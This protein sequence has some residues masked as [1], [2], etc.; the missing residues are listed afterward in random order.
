M[1]KKGVSKKCAFFVF[2]F[3]L[4]DEANE[5]DGKTWKRKISKKKQKSSVFWVQSLEHNVCVVSSKV[6][7]GFGAPKRILR[8]R[9]PSLALILSVSTGAALG[10]RRVFVRDSLVLLWTLYVQP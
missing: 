1:S 3:L 10:L 6:G 7:K 4:L 2:V 9:F 5:K 8:C